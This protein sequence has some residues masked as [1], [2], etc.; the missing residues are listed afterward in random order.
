LKSLS[1]E[2]LS[3][4]ALGGLAAM[5]VAL[6]QAIAF[7]VAIYSPLGAEGAAAGA[8]AGLIGAAAIGFTA[9]M[10]GGTN[11]LIS[12]PCAPAAAVMATLGME[13]AAGAAPGDPNRIVL[14]LTL[15]ALAAGGLQLAFG[16]LGGGRLIKYIP[17]PVVT[18]YLSG[19]GVL[20]FL[21][22]LPKLFGWPQGTP[23]LDG[24]RDPALLRVPSIV[25]GLAA[26]LA[27]VSAPKLTRKVPAPIF[28]LLGGLCAYAALAA[29]FPEL[30]SLDGNELVVGPLGGGGGGTGLEL[31]RWSAFP[32][33]GWADLR[34]VVV[35]A[36][37]LSVLLSMDTLK[38]CVVLDALTRSRHDS[39]Q[40]LI[41]Q[42]LAN[43]AS[44]LLG[45]VPGAGTMGATLVNLQS[46]GKTRLSGVLEGG[47]A[48]AAFFLLGRV[49]AWV[50]IAALAGILIVVAWRMVDRN[51][52]RLLRNRSTTFDFAVMAS[53]VGVAIA[54]DLMIAAGVGLALS[55]LLFIRDQIRGSVIRR[56]VLGSQLFSKQR[57]LP[58]AAKVLERDGGKTVA[59]ELQGSLFFGTTDQLFSEL[60]SDLKTRRFVILD[61]RRVQSVDFT[62]AHMLEQIEAMLAAQG[63]K[64]LLSSLP[65]TLPSGQDLK[66]Y[67]D[68]IGLVAPQKGARVFDTMD[69]ALAW[70][71]ERILEEADCPACSEETPLAQEEIDLFR[72]L[73]PDLRQVL[74]DCLTE[75]PLKSGETA[76]RRGDKGDELFVIRRGSVRIVL[77]LEGGRAH[78]LA[79][80]G[81]GDFFGEIAFIDRGERS[82]DAVAG[83]D[84]DL[85]IL[86]RTRFN[87]TVKDF[88]TLGIRIFARIALVQGVRLRKADHEIQIL[89][90]S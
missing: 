37:T 67:F 45:G 27:M 9:A 24:L 3:E 64:L 50:P 42:G 78:H 39:N 87:E 14:L 46:G 66:A 23:L 19:V 38:T 75:R 47:F 16:A 63:G 33:V 35:P 41:G 29:A 73:E 85:F 69:D 88:P 8:I 22:Q 32:R 76:F 6:P 18:G 10:F 13:L 80:F 7:G 30:R 53:V 68:E 57:R 58:E 12:A 34:A 56:K 82:A 60:E 86:P 20:I 52:F 2:H 15:T 43:T 25:V 74:A 55:I 54:T 51:S 21:T 48:L 61:L 72:E 49:I 70:A 31:S 83:S 44:A 17:Y 89:Q 1:A 77:P 79:T 28:G 11:R 5:L 4:D 65:S 59:C 40:E 90:E 26:V 36:L 84:T 71:E 81:R 62:A